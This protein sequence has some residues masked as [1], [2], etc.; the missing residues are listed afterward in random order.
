MPNL[1]SQLKDVACEQKECAGLVRF[2]CGLD[3]TNQL[4]RSVDTVGLM[5]QVA[6]NFV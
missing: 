3:G 6:A 1:V 5:Y 4:H 2:V